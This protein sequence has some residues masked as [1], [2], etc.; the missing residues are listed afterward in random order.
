[1]L[2][3]KGR[4]F[5]PGVVKKNPTLYGNGPKKNQKFLKCTKTPQNAQNIQKISKNVGI[6]L[7]SAVMPLKYPREGGT[8]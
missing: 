1:M 2:R 4:N 3:E 8:Q 5:G 7:Q 6:T